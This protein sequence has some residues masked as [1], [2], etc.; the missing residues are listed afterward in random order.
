MNPFPFIGGSYAARSPAFDAQRTVNLYPETSGSGN[1]K[2]VA[3]LVGTPGL[4]L[5]ATL[6]TAPIRGCLRVSATLGLIAA[7]A[8]LYSVTTA[9]AFTL[10]GA[11]AP[12]LTPVSMASDGTYVMIVTGLQG[13]FLTLSTM[14][15]SLIVNAA[16]VGADVVDF[17]DGFFVFNTPNTKEFQITGLYATTIDALDFA[18]AEALPDT[19]LTLIVDHD[20]LWLFSSAHTEVWSN[21]GAALFPFQ[22]IQGAV[23]E[24]GCAAKYSVCKLDNTVVWLTA[25]DRGQGTVQK[26]VGYTPQRISDH[27]LEYAIASYS[28]IDDAVGYSY[29][30]EGHLFYMLTFPTA[31]ATWCYDTATGL[32]HERAWRDPLTGQLSQ[33]RS[34]CH[35]AYAGMNIVGDYQ[36][37]NLYS[38]DL[39][40][41]TDNGNILPAIRQCPHIAQGNVWQFFSKLWIDAQMGV[42]TNPAASPLFTVVVGPGYGNVGYSTADPAHS[43]D[44]SINGVAFG[45]ISPA[46]A[47]LDGFTLLTVCYS[48]QAGAFLIVLAGN[49]PAAQF[50]ITCSVDGV[51]YTLSSSAALVQTHQT[52]TEWL[53]S[54]AFPASLGTPPLVGSTLE[55]FAAATAPLVAKFT[56]QAANSAGTIGYGIPTPASAAATF[57]S[58][59]TQVPFAGATPCAFYE[60]DGAV[61]WTAFTA[62]VAWDHASIEADAGIVTLQKSAGRTLAGL[63]AYEITEFSSPVPWTAGNSYTVTFYGPTQAAAAPVAP[64]LILDWSDDGGQSF[65]SA[66]TVSMGQLGERK[67][68]AIFRRLGKSRDRVFRATITDPVKRIFIGAGCDFTVGS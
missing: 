4:V 23:I 56:V 6:P 42:G 32:W 44:L 52:S 26:A 2:S 19:L 45:S 11:I 66:L 53:T 25:D 57:G 54:F 41:Y 67:V 5:W 31:K 38:L 20:E 62:A 7:G 36:N 17:I 59:V 33:H 22:R 50:S 64:R 58:V 21:V 12:G 61:F 46:G 10:I 30:Q 51:T 60:V 68:R 8:A 63:G 24:Q 55:F 13:Y 43:F 1:S 3:M 27:A 40:T 37:G 9:G 34:I 47:T 15:L 49:V 29:Q 48:A 16:F 35:M 18:S 28:R 65:G 39:D 14:A